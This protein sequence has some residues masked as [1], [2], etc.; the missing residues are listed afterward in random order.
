MTKEYHYSANHRLVSETSGQF[1]GPIPPQ[2]FLNKFL[3]F[4]S[5]TPSQKCPDLKAAFTANLSRGPPLLAQ[6]LSMTDATMYRQLFH[7]HTKL[8]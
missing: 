4:F 2:P 3:P 7:P 6:R 1:M 8:L 5:G